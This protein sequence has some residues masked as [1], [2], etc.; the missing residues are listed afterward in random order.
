MIQHRQNFV[1]IQTRI[2]V[3]KGEKKGQVHCGKEY[4]SFLLKAYVWEMQM[5]E[6][7][8]VNIVILKAVRG[9]RQVVQCGVYYS[10][11]SFL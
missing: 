4:F 3:S 9:Q 2:V 10:V 1:L 6:N 5:G 7:T 8:L 11:K